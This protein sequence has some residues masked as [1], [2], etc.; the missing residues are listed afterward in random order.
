MKMLR[1]GFEADIQRGESG[2][3]VIDDLRLTGFVGASI[4]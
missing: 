4:E 3:I 2:S 1:V